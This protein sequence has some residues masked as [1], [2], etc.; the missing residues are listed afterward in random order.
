MTKLACAHCGE[1]C[2]TG[3]A[4]GQPKTIYFDGKPF[5]CTGCRTVYEILAQHDLCE[6]YQR[7]TDAGISMRKRPLREDE[8]A[9]LD[10][11]AT[12]RR[13][14]AFSSATLNR[15]IWTVPSLH[16]VSCVWLLERLDRL[17]AGVLASTVD[18]MRRT[19][20]VDY[21]PQ[22]TTLRQVAETMASIGYSPLLR[23]E[24]L[25]G[26]SPAMKR[27]T[28]RGMY[29]RIGIAGF[30]AGNT[31]MM[32]I[33]EYFAGSAGVERPLM[34]AFRVLSIAL[35]VPVLVY[36]A[37]PWWIGARAALKGRRINLDVP[38]ALG[39]AVLFARSVFDIVTGHGSGYLDSF[40]GLIFFLLIGR[41]FQQKAFDALSFDR[42]YRSFFPLS[43]RIQ[44]GEVTAVVPIEQLKIGDILSVRNA[45]VVPCDSIL[46]SEIG[47]IDY[48]FVTGESVPVECTKDE[49]VYSGGKVMGRAV[50]LI[51]ARNVSHSELAAMWDRSSERKNAAGDRTTRY[52]ELSD[53][54]GQWFTAVALLIA[55]AGAAVW[56]PDWPKAFSI[57]TA[58]LI[59]ACPCAL[60]LAAPITLGSA[61]GRLGR[62]GIYLKNMGVLLDLDRIS[63]I[64]F[65]KTGTLTAAEHDIAFY[66]RA[67]EDREWHAILR[68][69]HESTH[70]V[71]RAIAGE[72]DSFLLEADHV[73][74]VIGK[75]IS[76]HAAGHSI[77]IGSS[78]FIAAH[79]DA[80]ISESQLGNSVAAAVAIDGEYA[81]VFT[82]RPAVREGVREM[83]SKLREDYRI[84]L[85]SGDSERDRPLLEPVFGIDHLRFNCR[86]DDKIERIMEAREGGD[87][88][89]MVGDG[90]ND[91]GAMGEADVAIAVTDDT[92][93]L[94]PACDVIMNAASITKLPALLRYARSMKHMI[95]TSL[96]FSIFYN[97]LGLTLAI[98]GEL[99][100]LVA[101]ILMPVSSLT[102]IAISVGGARRLSRR[103]A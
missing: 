77:A 14:L 88:V 96:V 27:K 93:T 68:I 83:I 8:Y 3:S 33:A 12:E 29:A 16:C 39:I 13:L 24:D 30:A 32:Y 31:M 75:G 90:L 37:S 58:V 5:C 91:A 94:V 34:F 46:A 51:A 79:C 26:E 59:I 98:I 45:E 18:I 71:S 89:L 52:L 65:D 85:I 74:E 22:R 1:P 97:A 20:T 67:L 101:A 19:V 2:D 11:A 49:M 102:V 54:F 56:L 78:E 63:S 9:V 47:Y 50:R 99:S 64:V 53:K 35:S 43:V 28:S 100:P 86:P 84:Q 103:L 48:S 4:L 70:P 21:D 92:A 73:Q 38:V 40:N 66:G 69:A 15:I 17:D 7:D 82:F 87:A 62:F 81:G 60:T 61:M 23:L 42:T 72:H 25:T 76:G 44:R 36:C 6:Y 95:W 41:L 55:A 80:E 57:F 10:D